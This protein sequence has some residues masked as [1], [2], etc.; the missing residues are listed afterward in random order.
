MGPMKA[1]VLRAPEVTVHSIWEC[2]GG[3]ADPGRGLSRVTEAGLTQAGRGCSVAWLTHAQVQKGP[4]EKAGT[5]RS[6]PLAPKPWL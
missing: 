6:P 3:P 5:L 4:G 2:G 1:E